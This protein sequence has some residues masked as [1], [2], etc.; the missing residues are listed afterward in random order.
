MLDGIT[1]RTFNEMFA[2]GGL[3]AF[4]LEQP[5][6]LL[7]AEQNE[8]SLLWDKSGGYAVQDVYSDGIV[9]TRKFQEQDYIVE[10]RQIAREDNGKLADW[11]L[12]GAVYAKTEPAKPIYMMKANGKVTNDGKFAASDAFITISEK[13]ELW[14]LLVPKFS[15]A[16]SVLRTVEAGNNDEVALWVSDSTKK[17]EAIKSGNS[18]KPMPADFYK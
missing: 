4:A 1:R 14:S 17:Y 13:S 9:L 12:V 16:L 11:T 3:A 5:L 15:A 18:L 7:A 8:I 10:I 6:T 2:K